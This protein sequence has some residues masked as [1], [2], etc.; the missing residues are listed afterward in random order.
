[1]SEGVRAIGAVGDV[2]VDAIERHAGSIAFVEGARRITYAQL[3]HD[4][5]HVISLFGKRGVLPGDRIAQLSRNRYEMAVAMLACYVGGFISVPLAYNSEAA[6]HAY[7]IRDCAPALLLVEAG[8]LDRVPALAEGSGRKFAVLTHE[9]LTASSAQSG[10]AP[11]VAS[12]IDGAGCVRL[13]YTGGTTGQPK[14]VMLSSSALAFAGLVLANALEFTAQTSF[15]LSAPLSHGSGSFIVP[16][17]SKGGQLVVQRGFDL[18]AMID[19]FSSGVA[20]STLMVPTMLYALLDHPRSGQ[21]PRGAIRRLVYGAAP[22][23]PAR[24]QQALDRF[25]YVLAQSYGQTEAPSAITF[26][27]PEDHARGPQVLASAGKPYPGVTLRL[28]ANGLPLPRRSRQVGEICLRAPHVMLGYWG[29][30]GL[31]AEALAGGWLHTGDLAYEDE[32]GYLYIVDRLKD[33]V[34][35]GGFNVYSSEVEAA[36]QGHSA[37]RYSAVV[38]TPHDKWGEAVHAFV[39]LQDG[40]HATERDLQDFVRERLGPVKTPKA[41][42]FIA[43]LPLTKVGKVDKNALRAPFWDEAARQVN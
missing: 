23:S 16:V 27:A 21:I 37:V 30:P 20:N 8:M 10:A 14:G 33:M 39:V 5:A 12:E 24:V 11:L 29:K 26:L 34:I 42:D 38:G 9:E 6:E 15:L 31:T 7:A 4:I 36:L 13:A 2:L 25:G 19:A 43:K 1:M 17:L 3:G 32:D 18:D 40:R 28:V 35:S 41:I 22:I